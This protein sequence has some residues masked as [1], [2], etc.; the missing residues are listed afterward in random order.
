[1]PVD[2][3]AFNRVILI[4]K[5]TAIDD[6]VD[7]YN[8]LHT[9]RQ[10]VDTPKEIPLGYLKDTNTPAPNPH[11]L[12]SRAKK[13]VSVLFGP[14]DYPNVLRMYNY[15]GDI[16]S[17]P[18][19]VSDLNSLGQGKVRADLEYRTSDPSTSGICGDPH[20]GGGSPYSG[21]SSPYA[22]LGLNIPETA[23]SEQWAFEAISALSETDSSV[24][25]D[26]VHI[27]LFDT[28]HGPEFEGAQSFTLPRGTPI[29]V[30]DS[31]KEYGSSNATPDGH[32]GQD[33]SWHGEAVASVA[34]EL[35][36]GATLSLYRILNKQSCGS[37]WTWIG[38]LSDLLQQVMITGDNNVIVS[39]S[40]GIHYFPPDSSP[41][42]V[43]PVKLPL[44]I[45][46]FEFLLKE[47]QSR[48]V[49]FVAASG[50]DSAPGTTSATQAQNMQFPAN[51]ESVIGVAASN[52]VRERSCFSNLG[53]VTAPGGDGGDAPDAAHPFNPCVPR[54]EDALNGPD[55]CD[56]SKMEICRYGLVVP[57][58]VSPTKYGF[59]SG[60]SVSTPQVAALLALAL[61][62]A[63]GDRKLAVCL[64]REGARPV[65]DSDLGI[66]IINIGRTLSDVAVTACKFPLPTK[67]GQ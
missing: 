7:E 21:G 16:D 2:A 13:S 63:E 3:I 11:T 64:I 10:L 41:F 31:I 49:M 12:S 46:T 1:V 48:G 37:V 51:Y 26:G 30:I 47:L 43:G 67:D 18:V 33:F 17:L 56:L 34:A 50:N 5:A 27:V 44:A 4:G 40:A 55:P 45:A 60:T 24:S 15:A 59:A 14:G 8:S 28:W 29:T 54:S 25:A 65:G 58:S 39:A 19:A 62:K 57:T 22:G 23:F 36:P 53:D 66:G 42:D 61:K 32:E 52:I 20:S 9:D 35:A 38:A 6:V